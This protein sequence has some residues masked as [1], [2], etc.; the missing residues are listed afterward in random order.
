MNLLLD[1]L[2]FMSAALVV[3]PLG[4]RLG[5][6]SVLGYLC[7]G[8]IIGPGGAH[9]IANPDEVL[10]FAELGVVF[11]LFLIGLE[12]QPRRLWTMRRNVFVLGSAEIL[13]TGTA[14]GAV[15]YWLFATTATVALIIGFALSLSS[16]AFVL[17]LLSERR[18]LATSHG[19][20]AF[21]ILLFQ[22]IAVIPALAIISIL[23]VEA[24]HTRTLSPLSL[25][26]VVVLLVAVRYCLRP[27]LRY[28]ASTG[29]NEL[30]AAAGLV[31]VLGIGLAMES[32]GISMGLGAFIAGMLV[33]D[34]EY[35]HQIETDITPFKGLL[36]GLFFMA[37]GMSADLSL[38][39]REPIAVVGATLGLVALKTVLIVPVARLGGLSVGDALRT[40]I[41]LSQGGEFAFVLLTAAAGGG[42]LADE[43]V[44]FVILV[45]TLS[46]ISTPLLSQLAERIMGNRT[47][48][49]HTFDTPGDQ[50]NPVVI[51][52]FGRI[53]QIVARVLSM[54]QIPFTALE[55]D[56]RQVEFVRQY[57]N[58]IYFGDA[59]R[60]DAL[61]SA[62][63]PT[64][65]AL[66]LT[67]VDVDT[68]VKIAGII[69]RTWPH[70]AILARARNRRHE[71]L[72]R[73]IGVHFVIRDTLLSSLALAEDLLMR[74]GHSP[75]AARESVAAFR[76]HDEATLQRQAAVFN[77]E[78]AFHQTTLEA[79][80]E[81]K[82]LFA[83]DASRRP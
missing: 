11:L 9:F 60:L 32:V 38:L 58:E 48:E 64:A 73:E 47:E 6:S 54:H 14:I 5:I 27:V 20:T 79:T 24:T 40:A 78:A 83:D 56:P 66:V 36:L 53:G 8:L 35:R 17:Q 72:L 7:A 3:V 61:R 43:M 49:K 2:I 10:H 65:R 77:D 30:F 74:L 75:T 71:L 50:A 37:V 22:D 21:G 18:T 70:V 19:R 69:R 26:A 4:K 25:L 44:A 51:A 33:A 23:A 31:L 68:S 76:E 82:Q 81:L 62:H 45:V 67:L 39:A 41:V 52:G 42:L 34:S 29:I 55:L 12:L 15:C 13:L 16:T 57:G 80:E 63:V 1:A 59:T 46:M 28:I